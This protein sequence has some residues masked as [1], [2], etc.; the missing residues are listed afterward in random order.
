MTGAVG[1]LWCV[2]VEWWRCGGVCGGGGDG[3]VGWWCGRVRW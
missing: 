3:S 1:W 2:G